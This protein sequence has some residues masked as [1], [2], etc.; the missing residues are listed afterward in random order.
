MQFQVFY[1]CFI[2]VYLFLKCLKFIVNR[3]KVFSPLKSLPNSPMALRMPES[4]RFLNVRFLWVC[5]VSCRLSS[6]FKDLWFNSTSQNCCKTM[7]TIVATTNTQQ[8]FLRRFFTMADEDVFPTFGFW[9][10]SAYLDTEKAFWSIWSQISIMVLQLLQYLFLFSIAVRAQTILPLFFVE[11]RAQ[12]PEN[13]VT[14]MNYIR[15]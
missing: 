2:F 3:A 11:H 1:R 14:L 6:S 4:P 9:R 7:S 10:L 8:V 12:S 15:A 5:L 13:K